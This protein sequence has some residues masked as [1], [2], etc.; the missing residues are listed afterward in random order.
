MV[1]IELAEMSSSNVNYDRNSYFEVKA[2]VDMIELVEGSSHPISTTMEI[3][4]SRSL[5]I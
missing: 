2:N 5:A 3:A 4:M 1:M